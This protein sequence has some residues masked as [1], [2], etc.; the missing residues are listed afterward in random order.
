MSEVLGALNTN[1]NMIIKEAYYEPIE[2]SVNQFIPERYSVVV[3]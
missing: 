2:L 1:E 3:G